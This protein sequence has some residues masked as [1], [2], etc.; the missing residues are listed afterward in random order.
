MFPSDCV[1]KAVGFD[2]QT[3]KKENPRYFLVGIFYPENGN[4][5]LRVRKLSTAVV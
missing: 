1:L 3:A 4:L 5:P 2:K